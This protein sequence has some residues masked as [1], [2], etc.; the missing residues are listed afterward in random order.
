LDRAIV[1]SLW[2]EKLPNAKTLFLASDMSDHYPGLV[3]FFEAKQ[4]GPKPF[5]FFDM[6]SSHTSFMSIVATIWR[7]DCPGTKM[8]QVNRK[9]NWLEK[10]LQMLN[11]RTFGDIRVQYA[12]A[13]EQLLRL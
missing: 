11:K 6:C 4:F 10:P 7:K 1:S 9:L 13:K 8:N 12:K 3:K 5:K 2:L